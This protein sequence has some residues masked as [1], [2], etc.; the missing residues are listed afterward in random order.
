MEMF[1]TLFSTTYTAL[2]SCALCGCC[3]ECAQ[4]REKL[5]CS[6][7]QVAQLCPLGVSPTYIPVS[8]SS[9]RY[10]TEYLVFC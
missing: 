3:V 8:Q 7:Q 2:V 10:S 9:A 5:F 4:M 1:N 6:S